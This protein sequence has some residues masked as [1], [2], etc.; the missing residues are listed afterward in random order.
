MGKD[1][2]GEAM[3][4]HQACVIHVQSGGKPPGSNAGSGLAIDFE[5]FYLINIYLYSMYYLKKTF[6]K[7]LKKTQ[8]ETMTHVNIQTIIAVLN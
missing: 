8:P 4:R 5:I 6:K 7:R 3:S 2:G 1:V